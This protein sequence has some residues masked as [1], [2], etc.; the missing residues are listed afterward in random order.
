MGAETQLLNVFADGLDLF[1]G[2]L[3]FHNDQHG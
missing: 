2:G 3:G 1:R